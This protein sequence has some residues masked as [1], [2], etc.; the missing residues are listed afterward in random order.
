MSK[1]NGT[2][3]KP[4]T[5]EDMER[6][7]EIARDCHTRSRDAGAEAVAQ[8]YL[9][10]KET[11][12]GEGKKWLD[13]EIEKFNV[14]AETHN[15][16]LNSGF[17]RAKKFV[18]GK[19]ALNDHLNQP[20]ADEAQRKVH[21]EERERLKVT[22]KLPPAERAALKLFS[23]KPRGDSSAYMPI[24]RYVFNFNKQVHGS[25][26]SRYCLVLEWIGVQ[27]E[28]KA[29]VD[30][31]TIKAAISAAGGF[32]HVVDI[33]REVGKTSTEAQKDAEIIREAIAAEAK[34]IAREVAHKGVLD[35][36]AKK[37]KDGFVLLLGRVS[38]HGVAV[39]G[40]A[41]SSD[42]E[43]DSAVSRFGKT[44][45]VGDDDAS[46]EFMGRVI[47][48]AA[49][50]KDKQEIIGGADGK[51]KISTDRI[52]S[53]K[54]DHDGAAHL[55]VSVNHADSSPIFYAKPKV[56]N[57]VTFDKG[58]CVLSDSTRKR[59]EKEM[60]DPARRRFLTLTVNTNPER[61][62]GKPAESP[63]SWDLHN[64]ALAKAQ[65]S[66]ANQ[67]FYWTSLG[68]VTAKP[69]D[70]DNFNP[71]FDC[72]L[73]QHELQ[74]IFQELLKPWKSNVDS[75]K[76]TRVFTLKLEEQQL[77]V[78]CGDADPMALSAK[79]ACAENFSMNFRIQDF[80]ALFEVL[81]DLHG[82]DY[83]LSGDQAGLLR[84]SWSDDYGEYGFHLPTVGTDGKLQS[85]RIAPMRSVPMLLAAE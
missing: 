50:I 6:R 14:T 7:V 79:V 19:L 33:Q 1:G 38:D 42:N 46:M 57:I 75:K 26:V 20:P 37:T 62:T 44:S 30:V 55:V 27:F 43:I 34:G 85:R 2:L 76:S 16:E 72:A 41:L 54:A 77:S 70:I 25:L 48:I 56:D 8:A 60:D 18:E 12:T 28:G 17:E 64:R 32:D 67:S 68:K 84:L 13:A 11:R 5:K 51:Q 15:A 29:S 53:L 3:G 49:I 22:H 74:A 82:T 23:A 39:L 59:M 73:G 9:L 21:D 66:T 58:S 4:L 40:E 36:Q 63:L 47:D 52:F 10:F 80:H 81:C 45:L 24:V 78:I 69:L 31:D 35:I 71:Q 83:R 65:R 61:A